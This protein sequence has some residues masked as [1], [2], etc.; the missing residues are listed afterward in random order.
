MSW[1]EF[2]SC[3]KIFQKWIKSLFTNNEDDDQDDVCISL[4]I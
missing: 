1:A 2:S 3:D 4:L